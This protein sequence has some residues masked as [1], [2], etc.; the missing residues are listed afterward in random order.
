MDSAILGQLNNLEKEVNSK[1]ERKKKTDTKVNE[2]EDND[3]R[4]KRERLVGCM[5]SIW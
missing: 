1:R 2:G 5:R 3:I 4:D